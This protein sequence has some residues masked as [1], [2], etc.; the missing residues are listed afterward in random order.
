MSDSAEILS[1]AERLRARIL[2]G[3]GRFSV[4]VATTLI[5][6][7]D[8][9]VQRRLEAVGLMD[10]G[11]GASMI[12]VERVSTYVFVV[13]TLML[14]VALLKP[15]PNL[16]IRFAAIYVGFAAIQVVGNVLGMVTSAHLLV[17][18][19]LSSLWDVGA[20]YLMT[21]TVFMFI[22]VLMDLTTPGG[23]FVWPSREGQHAPTPNLF[24]Y[25]FISLNVNS[26][27]GPTSEAVM[28]RATKLIMATQVL[29][30]ILMLTVLI[31]RAA[32]AL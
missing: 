10:S 30:A 11:I 7:M 3:Q 6:T 28:S 32:S 1:P 23:A 14:L 29:L 31:A 16:I 18:D 15:Y 13:T 12:G 5:W 27:Y 17:G 20:V 4:W 22:Y 9:L 2:Q 25:L 24:D 26:T 21:V 8:T 19:G